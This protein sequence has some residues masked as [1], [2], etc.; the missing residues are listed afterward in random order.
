MVDYNTKLNTVDFQERSFSV[1]VIAMKASK[2]AFFQI[3]TYF[4][5]LDEYNI[6]HNRG[7]IHLNQL[8]PAFQYID[9][10]DTTSLDIKD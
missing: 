10:N 2:T 6:I 9:I 5:L 3:Q 4:S 1:F 8:I 7:F